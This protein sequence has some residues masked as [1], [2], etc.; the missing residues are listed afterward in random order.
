MEESICSSQIMARQSQGHGSQC[1]M[2]EGIFPLIRSARL[3]PEKNILPW[4]IY[5]PCN[6]RFKLRALE[7]WGNN[8]YE[9][10]IFYIKAFKQNPTS[11]L[12]LLGQ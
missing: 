11:P 10:T 2:V 5:L 6:N 12:R 9:I 8:T 4:R 1:K 7:F 3:I